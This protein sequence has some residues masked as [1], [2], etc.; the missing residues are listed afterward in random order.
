MVLTLCIAASAADK[1]PTDELQKLRNENRALKATLVLRDKRIRSL[2]QEIEKLKAQISASQPGISKGKKEARIKEKLPVHRFGHKNIRRRSPGRNQ[3]R[4]VASR[5]WDENR[6]KKEAVNLAR[7]FPEAQK[8]N[9]AGCYVVVFFDNR[10]YIDNW[11]GPSA[12][13]VHEHEERHHIGEV[14]VDK[15]NRGKLY[16]R[17]YNPSPYP[18]MWKYDK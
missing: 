5:R 8:A 2:E 15:D 17:I 13:A 9:Y 12:G 4:A 3:I 11:T 6:L 18:E 14:L 1:A 7:A 16:G 10:K